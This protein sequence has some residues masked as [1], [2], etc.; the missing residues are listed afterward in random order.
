M[1][2]P[3]ARSKSAPDTY[4]ATFKQVRAQRATADGDAVSD[5]DTGRSPISRWLT[6]AFQYSDKVSNAAGSAWV[7][8]CLVPRGSIVLDALVRLDEAFNGTGADSVEI[9]DSDQASGYAAAIDLTTSVANGPVIFRDANA[10]Y[11]N[12][13]SDASAGST[14]PQ[15]YEDGGVVEIELATTLPTQGK[16]L[17]FLHTISYNEDQAAEW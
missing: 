17:L 6:Y 11:V 3:F 15:Y 7:V 5:V 14:G 1:T 9:G 8:K 13:A 2:A 12:K 10:V 4:Y 16:A